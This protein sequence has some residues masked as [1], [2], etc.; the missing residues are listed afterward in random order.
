MLQDRVAV[1]TGAGR[2]IGKGIAERLAQKG[3]EIVVNDIN[4]TDAIATAKSIQRLGGNAIAVEADVTQ[5]AQVENLMATAEKH[6]GRLDILVNNAGAFEGALLEEMTEEQWDGVLSVDLKGAFLCTQAAAPYMRKNGYGRVINISSPEVYTGEI[7]MAN[8][9]SAKAGLLGLTVC[10]A[11]EFSRWV[12]EEGAVMTC[13]CVL[14][15]YHETPMTEE[16][17]PAAFRDMCKRSVP[18][19]RVSDA[20]T[21]V[22]NAVAFLASEKAS[23]ITG[24]KIPVAGGLFSC[25]SAY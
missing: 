19:G 8:Y 16:M 15:G 6:F 11:Q 23:Y 2:G 1:I 12:K 25:I 3:A 22:G 21:D 24:A 13:N 4:K 10:V 14:A 20:A 17:V 5:K 7:G 18:L 9:I